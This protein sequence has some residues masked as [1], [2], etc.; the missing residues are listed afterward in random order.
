MTTD[1]MPTNQ[2]TD[3]SN[4]YFQN[5]ANEL[6]KLK[7]EVADLKGQILPASLNGY[8]TINQLKTL[9]GWASQTIYNQVYAGKLPYTKVSG[10]LLFPEKEIADV[11]K[12]NSRDTLANKIQEANSN[13][14][15]LK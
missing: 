5:I 2:G 10:K 9:T 1:V 15:T 8:L 12:K 3:L 4:V 14:F 7:Q 13:S 11:L 6:S